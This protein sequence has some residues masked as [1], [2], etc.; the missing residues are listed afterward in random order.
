MDTRG[1]GTRCSWFPNVSRHTGTPAGVTSTAVI[2][3]VEALCPANIPNSTAV[4]PLGRR[5][6]DPTNAA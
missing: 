2:G 1:R 6:A 4:F 3:P 5:R